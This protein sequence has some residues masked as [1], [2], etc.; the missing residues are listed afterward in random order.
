MNLRYLCISTALVLGCAVPCTDDGL[1]QNCSDDPALVT[2]AV[3]GSDD[4]DDDEDDDGDSGSSTGS[5]DDAP[6]GDEN[7]DEDDGDGDSSTS[8]GS[9]GDE[10]PL[11]DSSAG[12]GGPHEES[13][14][15]GAPVEETAGD[16]DGAPQA[17]AWESCQSAECGPDM[18]CIGIGSLAEY[19]S[20]CSPECESDDDC[21]GVNGGVLSWCALVPDGELDPQGCVLVCSLDDEVQGDCPG[22]MECVD[23]P[24]STTQISVCMWS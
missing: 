16:D 4:D 12:D 18:Q 17:D 24:G 21:P 5:N 6:G 15:D 22:S 8:S 13:A 2:V 1:R 9:H 19:D 7:D 10:Q 3:D 23:V 14:S 11:E 20:F